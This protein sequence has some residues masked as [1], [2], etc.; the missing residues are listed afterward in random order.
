MALFN[1][2]TRD[3]KEKTKE[4]AIK[5]KAKSK[6]VTTIK[7]GNGL[8]GRIAEIKSMVQKHLGK[9]ANDYEIITDKQR[10]QDY[11]KKCVLNKIISIDTETTGLDPMQDKIVGLCLY[12]PNEKAVYIPINHISYITNERLDNQLT[13]SE[14]ADELR[15]IIDWKIE[16]IMFNAKFDIRVIRNQLGLKN[17]Y[18]TWDCYLAA[19]LMNE[20]E[21]HG[22]NG[23]KALYRKYVLDG[24]EDTFSFD[25]LFNGITF[26]KIP[27][28]VGY[29]YAAH[30]AII[31]YELYQ[32]QKKYIYYDRTCT[33]GARN[34]MN[35]VSWVFFNI[36]M[37]CVDAVCNMEDNGIEL[38]LDYSEQLSVKYHKIMQEKIDNF[39]S[40]LKDYEKQ[41]AKYREQKPDSKLDNPINIG[42]PTQIAILLYD[43]IG[44]DVVDDKNPRG[45][46]EEILNKLDI[47]ICK[48]ILDYRTIDKLIGT[49]IDKLPECVNPNDGRIH[50][51]FNQYGADTGRMSS[52]DPN[53]QN[54]PSRNHD[55]RKMFK[56]SSNE[57]KVDFDESDTYI[58]LCMWDEVYTN[59]EWK[60]INKLI[61][62]DKIIVDDK[63]EIIITNVE[64]LNERTIRIHI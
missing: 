46:G 57:Y 19:R 51:S 2:P 54:I 44:V 24:K 7:S 12:T 30:D 36:E 15:V 58:D 13:E 6:S 10:L 3:N 64:V 39:Y 47:P 20:N 32:F 52:N 56:A 48:A 33:M 62:G 49:Y 50:C 21:G 53:L 27:P 55:I 45:T 41:I 63:E 9:F 16:I 11:L 8:L 25:A 38:D 14:V 4:I 31:T 59:T 23:L 61:R 60:S 37:P 1:I 40:I 34:G 42:S 26:D 35:G 22:N 18:C 17:I 29:L 28:N 5:S 43:I